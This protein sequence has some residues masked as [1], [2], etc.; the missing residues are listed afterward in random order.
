MKPP[1]PVIAITSLFFS[2]V[3]C[4]WLGMSHF[5]RYRTCCRSKCRDVADVFQWRHNC[6]DQP[7]RINDDDSFPRKLLDVCLE[8]LP[9]RGPR[10]SN[11]ENLAIIPQNL[12]RV[13][14]YLNVGWR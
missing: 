1:A 2:P 6:F 5:R 10:T 8:E 12:C 11:Y 14:A 4:R 3:L 9:I 13:P 7:P